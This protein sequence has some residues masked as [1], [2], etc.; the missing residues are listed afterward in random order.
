MRSQTALVAL[1]GVASA[2]MMVPVHNARRAVE[3][4]QTSAADASACL[5]AIE[6]LITGMPTPNSVVTAFVATA[7]DFCNISL[8]P[9]VESAYSSYESAISSWYGAHSKEWSSALAKCPSS[10]AAGITGSGGDGSDPCATATGNGGNSG[11]KTTAAGGSKSTS[12][13]S[14]DDS[15]SGS[16]SSAANPAASSGSSSSGSGSGTGTS[17][18][19]SSS[20]SSGAAGTSA[21]GKSAAH[22]ETGFAGAA[23]A[24]AGFL[25]VVAIL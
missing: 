13:G 25:A 14:S 2:N 16:S 18:S 11:S 20:A 15:G 7:T 6:S 23:I 17:G 8:P 5:D 9:S 21:T 22:R 10:A 3:A 12:S 24:L 4:R 1:A 19:G